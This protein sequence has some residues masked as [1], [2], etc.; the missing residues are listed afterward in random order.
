[1]Y[2]DI[3]YRQFGD[4]RGIL[5][6]LYNHLTEK[7]SANEWIS[8]CSSENI[9]ISDWYFLNMSSMNIPTVSTVP[10]LHPILFLN[11]QKAFAY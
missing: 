5:G 3:Y 8:Y 1:M 6:T 7:I 9:L 4:M 2:N 11:M 10:A